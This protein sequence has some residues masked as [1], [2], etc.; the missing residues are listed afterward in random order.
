MMLL[1][2]YIKIKRIDIIKEKLALTFVK[3]NNL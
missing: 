3:N 1:K 2:K